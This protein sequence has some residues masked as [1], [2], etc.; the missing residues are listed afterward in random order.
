MPLEYWDKREIIEAVNN[1]Q[2][3]TERAMSDGFNRIAKALEELT[4]EVK[5]LREEQS[6][7][8]DK[9]KLPAP[10]TTGG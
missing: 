5:A 7:K 8:L 10:T 4:K 6:P 9:A 1:A 2:K 3:K